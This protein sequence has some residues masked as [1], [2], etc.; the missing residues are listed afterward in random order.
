[1]TLRVVAGPP[2]N[3]KPPLLQGADCAL[4]AQSQAPTT[5]PVNRVR[6]WV[7]IARSWHQGDMEIADKD[8]IGPAPFH[9]PMMAG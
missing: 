4:A 2:G 9:T 3:S 7:G 5:M 6:G 1:M 8:T